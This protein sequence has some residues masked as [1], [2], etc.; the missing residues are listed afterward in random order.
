MNTEKDYKDFDVYSRALIGSNDV[1][2]TYPVIKSIIQKEG[3]DPYWFSFVYVGFYSLETAI[4]MCRVMPSHREW[5]PKVFAEK[6]STR[7]WGKFGH[8]RR[9]TARNITTQI[10]NF[11][12]ITHFLEF[13]NWE[14]K[15]DAEVKHKNEIWYD[16]L[17]SQPEFRAALQTLPFHGGWASFKLAE[18]WEKSLGFTHF[19]IP[20]LGV[21][22][23]DPNSNDGPVGGLRW[24][25]G[26]DSQYDDSW[27]SVWDDLGSRLARAWRVDIGKVETCLCKWHKMKSGKYYI[28]HDIHEFHE[29]EPV[30][31]RKHY[32]QIMAEHFDPQIWEDFHGIQK[33]WKSV[34]ANTGEILFSNF[35]DKLPSADILSI[36]L[37][38]FEER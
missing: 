12:A 35:A 32:R 38:Q 17:Q 31:G 18:I 2:P 7:E 4:K 16:S 20:D 30:L 14:D 15:K 25:Y 29:L 24:L 19:A 21:A 11:E 13:I 37:Q 5:N 3:F 23:R 8:E 34:Y 22:G 6:R 36:M 28:G 26:R 9:G 27:Y 33:Q 10:N 1:D